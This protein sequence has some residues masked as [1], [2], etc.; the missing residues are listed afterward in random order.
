MN[1]LMGLIVLAIL[2]E[3]LLIFKPAITREQGGKILAFVGILMLP[4]IVGAFSLQEHMEKSKKTEFCLSCHVMGK[5][6]KSLHVDD[7]EWIPAVH[8]Q[9]HRI[10][11]DQACFTCHTEYTM[12]GDFAAKIRGLRHLYYQYI[13]TIPDTIK[14]Y[15]KY[16]NRECLHCHD[17][18]RSFEEKSAHMQTPL[19]MDSLKHNQISCMTSGCHDVI[20]NVKELD[21]ADFWTPGQVPHAATAPTTTDSTS[22]SSASPSSTGSEAPKAN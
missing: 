3:L 22:G 16:N 4:V 11:S 9:N 5:Y 10:P 21:K 14:L 15:E 2:V 13:G 1:I 7:K 20:H 18:A 8:F 6:G 19:M 17:G 12:Y